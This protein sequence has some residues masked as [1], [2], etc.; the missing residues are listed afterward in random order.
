VIVVPGWS[1]RSFKANE[2][3][4]VFCF[5]DRVAQEKLGYFREDRIRV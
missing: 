1:W 4:V 3:V 5:S 2:D